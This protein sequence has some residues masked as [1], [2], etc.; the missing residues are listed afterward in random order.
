[1]TVRIR[2]VFVGAH[3]R[4]AVPDF[5]KALVVVAKYPA[6]PTRVMTE[7]KRCVDV[8][9]QLIGARNG[10]V[11]VTSRKLREFA[12]Y[13]MPPYSIVETLSCRLAALIIG[14]NN[15]GCS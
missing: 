7:L 14:E 13:S 2:N 1:M 4:L 10:T 3:A 6:D 9:C 15:G 12:A 5:P 8:L 11:L